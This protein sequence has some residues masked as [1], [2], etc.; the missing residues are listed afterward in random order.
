MG[1][2]MHGIWGLALLAGNV[3]AILNISQSSVSNQMKVIW[4]VGVVLLPFLGLVLWYFLGPR[5]GKA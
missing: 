1:V 2:G 4:I 5:G 3:W